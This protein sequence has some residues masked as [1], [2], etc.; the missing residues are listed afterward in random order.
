MLGEPSCGETHVQ[1]VRDFARDIEHG[2]AALFVGA[3][4]SMPAGYPSWRG[5]L[6]DIAH[7]LRLDPQKEP[8]L[9]GIV[10]YYLNKRPNRNQIAE[11]IKREFRAR[12]VPETHRVIARLPFPVIWTTNYDQLIEQAWRDQ[13]KAIE[14]KFKQDQIPQRNYDAQTVLYK[15]HGSVED[16]ADVVIATEDYELFVRTRGAFMTTLESDFLTRRF[17]F[18]GLSFTDHNLLT[19]LATMRR[20]TEPD[21]ARPEH[22]AILKRPDENDVASEYNLTDPSTINEYTEYARQ[23][24]DYWT[25]DLQ[26]RYGIQVE[27]VT[28]FDSILSILHD[29]ESQYVSRSV[30]IAGAIDRPSRNYAL[31][32]ASEAGEAA[33][34]ADLRLISGY[35]RNVGRSAIAGYVSGTAGRDPMPSLDRKLFIR[36]FPDLSKLD[37]ATTFA[38]RYREDMISQAG[39]AVVIAG[40]RDGK[41]S[42]GVVEEALIA[43]QNRR[44]VVP[45]SFTGGAAQLIGQR[46]LPYISED[47]ADG[48]VRRIM[49]ATRFSDVRPLLDALFAEGFHLKDYPAEAIAMLRQLHEQAQRGIP[50]PPRF[51][52]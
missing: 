42:P 6:A 36:P 35:G 24:F 2:S 17:L 1:L 46:L 5:L 23:R 29:I 18:L 31:A 34:K 38:T 16:A 43:A 8:D 45:L 27:I 33:A 30:F 32:A 9:A 39:A 41:V 12:K 21:K 20:L 22:F 26:R 14:V 19:M 37:D 13:G 7:E 3:G 51:S 44:L 49:T 50:L 15:M 10:Q 11:L 4:F 48:L 47:G 28:S 52:A 40:A 25:D